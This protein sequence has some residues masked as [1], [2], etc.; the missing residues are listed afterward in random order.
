MDVHATRQVIQL[1]RYEAFACTAGIGMRPSRAFFPI[2]TGTPISPVPM[3]SLL[4]NLA[5]MGL[6]DGL[7][8]FLE[9]SGY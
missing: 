9:V 1:A 4:A 2:Q 3:L 7:H 8:F 6:T 5:I